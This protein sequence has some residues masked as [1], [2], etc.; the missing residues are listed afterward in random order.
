MN[1]A[2]T[3]VAHSGPVCVIRTLYGPVSRERADAEMRDAQRRADQLNVI[4]PTQLRNR[5]RASH[6][7]RVSYT[8]R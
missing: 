4:V 6:S 5:S 7:G 3:V 2:Y 8:L 1:N